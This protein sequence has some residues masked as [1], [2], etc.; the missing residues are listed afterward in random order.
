MTPSMVLTR[1]IE[2]MVRLEASTS[3]IVDMDAS[4]AVSRIATLV[5]EASLFLATK[6]MALGVDL[7]LVFRE[8]ATMCERGSVIASS[9]KVHEG[10]AVEHPLVGDVALSSDT[11]WHAVAARMD[12]LPARLAIERAC[13]KPGVCMVDNRTGVFRLIGPIGQVYTPDWVL[14]DSGA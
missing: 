7:A 8:A 11:T 13:V 4:N 12:A 6:L 14:L 1:S 10:V 5:L 2:P 9:A 3:C